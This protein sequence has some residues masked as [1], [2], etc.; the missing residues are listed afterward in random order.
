[1]AE[2]T[3]LLEEDLIVDIEEEPSPPPAEYIEPSQFLIPPTDTEP[4][5]PDAPLSPEEED[6]YLRS[7]MRVNKVDID[8]DELIKIP[9]PEEA[10]LL[11]DDDIARYLIETRFGDRFKEG[12]YEL[13][14]DQG[15]S[16]QYLIEQFANVRSVGPYAAF[17]EEAGKAAVPMS[18]AV[19]GATIGGTLGS[20]PGAVAGGIT[21]FVLG[22][23]GVEAVAPEVSLPRV[24]ADQPAGTAGQIFGGSWPFVKIPQVLG[25]EG[26]SYLTN[27][28]ISPTTRF[29]LGADWV[30]KNINSWTGGAL[31][32]AEDFSESVLRG[33]QQSPMAARA[34][35]TS[36]YRQ[37][38]SAAAAGWLADEILPADLPWRGAAMFGAELTGAIID[39]VA[40]IARR[41]NRPVSSI[42]RFFT[43]RPQ[44]RGTRTGDEI[45]RL[46]LNYGSKLL[47]AIVNKLSNSLALVLIGC[48]ALLPSID[49]HTL[50]SFLR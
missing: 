12:D 1:M 25:T 15:Y 23:L 13:F 14:K 11:N 8:Y 46:L 32:I 31:R 28:F 34:F 40:I 35:A 9:H 10:R 50:L 30:G 6:R 39:P 18:S 24:Q 19:M 26:Y 38:G 16:S 5:D 20:L 43:M 41:V 27:S 36:E 17:M 22:S 7:L 21:G 37:I 44:T 3:D 45:N 47:V 4:L 33:A 49:A 48:P 29:N 42:G 2:N